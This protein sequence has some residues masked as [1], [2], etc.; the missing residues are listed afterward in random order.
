MHELKVKIRVGDLPPDKVK[1]L[2][3]A[4]VSYYLEEGVGD[5]PAN[6]KHGPGPTHHLPD[7]YDWDMEIE[8]AQPAGDA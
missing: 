4:A 2:I 6:E 7:D 8:A 5:Y 3:E 1:E